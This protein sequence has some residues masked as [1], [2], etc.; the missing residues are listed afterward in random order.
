[1]EKFKHNSIPGSL[2]FIF[3]FLFSLMAFSQENNSYLSFREGLQPQDNINTLPSRETL[4]GGDAYYQIGYT[5]SGALIAT[6]KVEGDN[7][8]LLYIE[9]F[10]KIGQVGA[11]ALPA[12][13]EIIAMPKGASGNI[14]IIN[15]EFYEYDGFM[16]HPALEPA[17][18]TEGAPEPEFW[19][20]EAI[21]GKNEFFPKNIVKITDVFL[22]RGSP[23]AVARV[24]PVQFN[25]VTGKIRV[26]TN[27]EYSIDYPDATG[28][29]SEIANDNSLHYTNLLKRN[30]INSD[31]IPDGIS[32]KDSKA[33][34][35]NYII[36]THDEYLSAANDLANW[37]RQL[38]YSVEVVSQS[39]WTA[40]Q[41]KTE[42][43]NRYNAWTPHPDYFVII[44]DHTGSYAVPGDVINTPYAPPND[45]P[46]AT[47]LYF[48]CM[49]G[50][51]DWHPDMAHGRISP[52][53]ATEAQTIVDKVINYE[54]T[55][56]TTASFYQ[57]GL[58]CAQYQ[59]D[60]PADTYA[61]RRF[62]HTSENIRDYT[63]GVLGYTV[64]RIY[65]T[66]SPDPTY[67]NNG[68]YSPPNTQIP[69]ELQSASFNWS[70]GSAD[71][72][73]AINAGK[74][75]VFHRDHGYVGG[76]GWHR[77]YY[78]TASMTS[79]TNGDLLPVIFSINCHT[80]EY[81]LSN[82]FAEKMLR[83]DNKGAVG[84]IAASYFSLSG[85]NDG[86]SIGMIDAIWATPGLYAVFGSGGSGSSYTIGAGNE[87]Y[88]MGDVMNQG[89]YAMEQN[90]GGSSPFEQYEYELFHWFGDPAMKIWTENPN[91]NTITATHDAT[92]DCSV[93]SFAISGSTAGATATLVFNDELIGE[94]I[95][96]GSGNGSISYS[97]T[98]PGTT[99]L[100]TISK[101]NHKPYE[102]SLSLVGSCNPPAV[103]TDPATAITQNTATLNGDIT[104]DFGN[105]VTES[106]FVYSTAV[107]PFIGGPG[108]T[109]IQTSPTVVIGTFSEPVSG[110]IASTTYH[111]KA[112]AISAGGTGYGNDVPL[113]TLCG[114]I[115]TLPFT[116]DFSTG[117]LPSCWQNIDNQGSGQV[118]EFD[119]PGGRTFSS[120]TGANGFA[121]LDSDHYGSGGSQDADLV[122]PEFD[123]SGFISINLEFEHYFRSYS[124]SDATLSYSTDGGSV[125]NQ[126]QNWTSSSGNPETFNQDM[127]TEVAGESS[128]YFKWNYTGSWGYYWF[129]DD[130]N[131]TGVEGVN[132]QIPLI[133]G[134]NI[135]SFCVEPGNPDMIAIVQPLIDAST[136]VKV[137]DEAGGFVQYIAGS[138]MNTI[139][140]MECTEGYY[141][142]LTGNDNLSTDGTEVSFPYDIPLLAGWNIMG[143]PCDVSQDA[144]TVLQPLIDDGYL[145]KVID[146]SGG[147]IQYIV[148]IGWINTIN[149]FDPG[150]GYHINVN[151]NCTLTLNDPGKGSNL[152]IAPQASAT[153]HFT[154]LTGNPFLPMNILIRDI[155]GDGFIVEDGDEIAVFDGDIEV[156]SLV[157]DK[158]TGEFQLITAR[159]DDPITPAPDGFSE[160]NQLA[161]RYWD[162]SEN[163][164]YTDIQSTHLFGNEPFTKL[165]TAGLD[166]K[167]GSLGQNENGL[168]LANYLGQNY[169]NPYTGQ[170]TIEYGVAEDAHV[171]LNIYDVYGRK[172]KIIEDKQKKAGKYLVKING[173]SMEAGIYYYK[174]QIIGQNSK[175]SQTQKMILF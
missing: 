41:V 29:F 73:S 146:E 53:T 13:N 57:N 149:T 113:T 83:M 78:T 105:T 37:K 81:Q 4:N 36:I 112:Y 62:C 10:S 165:G 48:A 50:G 2:S 109:Q 110:L 54:K 19:I 43:A 128:V 131:I 122:T 91:S 95:L 21:Y 123:F 12:R 5:F 84:V 139:G 158:S 46:F 108:V 22:S 171:V 125:W 71:I 64:E 3:L 174:L 39:S 82:C 172:V 68:Y 24:C 65:F 102:A 90:W 138:W 27:I 7:S 130:I 15:S 107:D 66:D 104:D 75:Y 101:T 72:T 159:A 164:Q 153:V 137:S 56:P 80:G 16:I 61:D 76:T 96:D 31:N 79:L 103:D 114:I 11:P 126:I 160:G 8:E 44:G 121:I 88:T 141:I 152:Y 58:N 154:S 17:I 55:P 169:P 134:W 100:L 161:F 144:M 20:D 151:T 89:L 25:P 127:S 77:P 86:V 9:G 98:V 14:T 32:F 35:K 6:I 115:N 145:V 118:W 26:Y 111:Y 92:I 106:G 94:T 168:P 34:E 140:N 170:T 155:Y 23:L 97:I 129:L 173:S 1:M 63:Q 117:A 157:I 38:G 85:Y 124:G 93:N 135:L 47:D 40:A 143:Y 42:I 136:L 120:T 132:Q 87:I 147:M 119:N 67:Y 60:N 69:A 49:D 99:V 28:L 116:Q 163:I 18:D 51:S 175:F 52:S 156:G 166:L 167:I 133:S 148:G 142:N 162:K 33:G 45:G 70:G 150:K 74:F 30:V 59:D